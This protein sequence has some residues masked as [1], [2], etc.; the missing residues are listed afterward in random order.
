MQKVNLPYPDVVVSVSTVLADFCGGVGF[1]LAS[2][3]PREM[4]SLATGE[5]I[6]LVLVHLFTLF[7]RSGGLLLK[8]FLCDLG[9]FFC[10]IC[11][12]ELP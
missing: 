10:T 11:A 8:L 9:R 2:G 7:E 4:P 6:H 12:L 1:H 5:T 3:L